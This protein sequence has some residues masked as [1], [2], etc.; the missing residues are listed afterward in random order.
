MPVTDH[1]MMKTLNGKWNLKIVD[2]ISNDATVPAQ[3][4]TW[5]SIAVPGCWEAYGLC[6]PRYDS[7]SPLTGYYRTTFTVP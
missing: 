7:P 2:G 6:K 5:S 4:H 3:D 1:K